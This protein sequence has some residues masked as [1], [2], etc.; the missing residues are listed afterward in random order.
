LRT[1]SYFETARAALSF[2]PRLPWDAG[3]R[4]SGWRLGFDRVTMG[5]LG[6]PS[7]KVRVDDSVFCC[8]QHPTWFASPRRRVLQQCQFVVLSVLFSV[9]PLADVSRT[10][11]KLHAIRLATS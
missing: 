5:S 8:H 4:L 6:V 10:I 9:H 7:F 1:P 3:R 11:L 2:D